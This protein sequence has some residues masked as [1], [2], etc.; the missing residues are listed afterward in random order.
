MT[1]K[2]NKKIIALIE[3][4]CNV[5]VRKEEGYFIFY[6][7]NACGEDYQFEIKDTT[8]TIEDIVNYCDGFD[9]DE[10]FKLWYGAN[11]GEPSDART[12]LDNCEEIGDNLEQLRDLLY[13][14]N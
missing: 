9:A 6:V 10:H 4:R 14:L 1:G 11:K 2:L 5:S 12:L 7:D 8:H 13:Y 3:E